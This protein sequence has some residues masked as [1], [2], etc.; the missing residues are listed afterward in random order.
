MLTLTAFL[1]SVWDNLLLE[2]KQVYDS[3]PKLR[4]LT[5]TPMGR[6]STNIFDQI[7]ILTTVY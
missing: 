7:K 2:I 5:E 1:R 6:G 3:L 4:Y